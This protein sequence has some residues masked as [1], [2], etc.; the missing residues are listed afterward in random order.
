MKNTDYF[1]IIVDDIHSV[2]VATTDG[3]GRPVTRCIDMMLY[4]DEGIY[5]LTARGKE[6]YD[7]LMAQKYIS[8][9]A[10]KDKKCVSLAGRV[11]CI[12]KRKMDEI[13]EKNTYM[14]KIYPEGTREPIEVFRI[15]DGEGNYFDISDP[16]NVRRGV[17]TIGGAKERVTGYFAGDKCI[18]CGSCLGVC[19]QQ[20]IDLA[21]IPAVI[22]QTRCLHCGNCAAACPVGAIERR[23]EIAV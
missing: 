7:Q 9:S 15:C 22:D 1:K 10:I 14:Q 19:P 12:G 21:K 13:F 3:D 20:C 23:S 2:V 18:G 4:D 11:E 6:F 16:S 17:F 5:F 8:L